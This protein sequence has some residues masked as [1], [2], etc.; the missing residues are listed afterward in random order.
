MGIVSMVI[1]NNFSFQYASISRKIRNIMLAI[2][3]F[4]LLKCWYVLPTYLLILILICS[5]NI[6]LLGQVFTLKRCF[7]S[8]NLVVEKFSWSK[9]IVQ[10]PII[11]FINQKEKDVS[12][13]HNINFDEIGTP[14]FSID[15]IHMIYPDVKYF[16]GLCVSIYYKKLS[17]KT[18][19]TMMEHFFAKKLNFLRPHLFLKS[20]KD[21]IQIYYE[22]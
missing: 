15:M 10:T 20:E 7:Q 13:Q 21:C 1:L 11:F 12:I 14:F 17:V 9:P 3:F 8:I 4:C 22:Q 16:S 5:T 6:M 2:Y 19:L 18:T